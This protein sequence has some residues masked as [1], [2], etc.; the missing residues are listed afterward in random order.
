MVHP[1][2]VVHS[3]VAYRDGS[4]LAQL[5]IPD[6]RVPIAFTLAWPNRF[7]VPVTRLDLAKL[8]K[9]TFEAPSEG[10]FPALRL[11]REV[12]LEGG[13]APAV[14]NAANEIA[15]E[16]FLDRRIGFLEIVEIVERTL[17]KLQVPKA[18]T[19]E[20]I[21]EIDKLAR[22]FAKALLPG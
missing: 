13:S 22:K 14:M 6:M 5:G 12:L 9:L 3:M 18:D 17:N 11:A 19:I 4:V 16:G 15:V 20:E 10:L 21:S 2:S 8:G 1:Q 7:S